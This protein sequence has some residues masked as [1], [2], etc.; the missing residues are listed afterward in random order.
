MCAGVYT[1][2]PCSAYAALKDVGRG[3]KVRGLWRGPADMTRMKTQIG[4]V[5]K[6]KGRWRPACQHWIGWLRK[7]FPFI[8]VDSASCAT[9]SAEQDMHDKMMAYTPAV[10]CCIANG[11]PWQNLCTRRRVAKQACISK[12]K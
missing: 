5:A 6:A 3:C 4:R 1:A 12:C 10:Q 9:P 8:G 7:Q 11:S 2:V